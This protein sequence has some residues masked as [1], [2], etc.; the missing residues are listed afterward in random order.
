MAAHDVS[1]LNRLIAGKVALPPIKR[2]ER[3]EDVVAHR[4]AHLTKY[5]DAA[6]A[7]RYVDLVNEVAARER[8]VV[9][10]SSLLAMAV[11]RNLA[12]LMAY[13]DEYEIAR[14]HSTPEFLQSLREEFSGNFKLRFNLAP[15]LLARRDP[16]TGR[17]VKGEYGGWMLTALKLLARLKVLRGTRLD[18]AGYTAERKAERQLIVDYLGTIQTILRELTPANHGIA[19]ELAAL[20]TGSAGGHV[21]ERAEIVRR[22]QA[23]LLEVPQAADQG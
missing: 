21:K 6:Y 13:K 22:A 11:A 7:R 18:I 10:Q 5:Q 14:L 9:P 2:E 19:A 23:E 8:E 3:F 1:T 15:P 20:P 4:S 12:K 17:L 16:Q